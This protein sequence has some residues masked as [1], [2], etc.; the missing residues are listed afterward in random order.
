MSR[1]EVETVISRHDA[2]FIRKD[3]GDQSLLLSVWL[4]GIDMLYLALGFEDGVLN[5][6][7]FGGEDNPKDVPK[8][9]PPNIE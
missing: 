9:A 3:N 5:K 4:G 1:A 7:Q 2:P 8:D 6:A